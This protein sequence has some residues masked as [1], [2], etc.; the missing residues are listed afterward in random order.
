[1]RFFF[2]LHL[3]LIL[4]AV[5]GP[6]C[7][8]VAAYPLT[9]SQQQRLETLLPKT[10]AKL[11][12]REP[13]H[14]ALIGDGVTRMHGPSTTESIHRSLAGVLL[15]GIE[16]QFFYTGGVRVINPLGQNAQKMNEHIGPEIT[17]E[18]F[19]ELDA[20]G[21]NLIQH[22]TTRAFLNE[23]DLVVVH[24]G[25]NDAY[26]GSLVQTYENALRRGVELCGKH[27]AEVILIGPTIITDDPNTVGWGLTRRYAAA[28]RTVARESGI[29]FLDPGLPLA[30]GI[31]VPLKGEPK[32]RSLVVSQSLELELFNH[33]AGVDEDRY[34]N[35]KAH[36]QAG[37]ALIE[38][39]LNG[40]PK[41]KYGLSATALH[42]QPNDL[43]I[44]LRLE[45]RSG[46]PQQGVLTALNLGLS[47]E[48]ENAYLPFK[49]STGAKAN[50]E[51]VYRRRAQSSRESKP[52]FYRE[53]GNELSLTCPALIGDLD[54]SALMETPAFVEPVS[55]QWNYESQV[56]QVESFPAKFTISN[57]TT[58]PVS[59]TYQFTYAKQR[60]TKSF[61][62]RP[63]EAKEFSA[64]C[65]LP[66]PTVL[67]EKRRIQL[68]VETGEHRLVFDREAEVTQN[69][70]LNRAWTLIR[71]DEY[72]VA[73][74]Q[75]LNDAL[76]QRVAM[77]AQAN[78][79]FLELTFDIVNVSLERAE[80]KPVLL[81]ELGIDGRPAG[82]CQTFGFIRPLNITFRPGRSQGETA[83]IV[84][85]AFGNGYDKAIDS[86]GIRSTISSDKGRKNHIVV[87]QIPR[88]YL[89]RHP[90]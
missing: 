24:L 17:V 77:T 26:T 59:G 37:Q 45:N 75:I 28:M 48:A 79:E 7:L 50:F 34:P 14:I 12:R 47:W 72:R 81:L 4:I 85:A 43:R 11:K 33:G 71:Q 61:L 88:I 84:T 58:K 82:E 16:G 57:P 83:P 60:A 25:L 6:F 62:L 76:R 55:V 23:P 90:W 69:L 70:G 35:A 52:K 80:R 39:F 21:L 38:Q 86:R 9:E 29:M 56:R 15:R 66:D 3:P 13:V 20:I 49:M 32:A 19:T 42:A 41:P 53:T 36:D 87:V 63:Q 30:R 78:A 27:G 65:R 8:P 2:F 22:L 54:Q 89:Y 5:A 46:E 67:R 10:Y 51:M 73:D 40:F 74:T 44:K 18:Q 1:M 31:P 64:L 68:Q